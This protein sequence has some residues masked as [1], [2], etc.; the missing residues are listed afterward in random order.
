MLPEHNY[1]LSLIAATIFADHR[2]LDSEVQMFVK[3]TAGLKVLQNA[4]PKLT[5]DK[6]LAWYDSNKEEI[7]QKVKAPY[8][9]DWFYDL[10]DKLSDVQEKDVIVEIMQKISLADGSIHVSERTLFTLAQRYW[11]LT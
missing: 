4:K 6:I 11:N 2:V 1:I 9:K 3:A 8:F 10:L 5:E 7:R